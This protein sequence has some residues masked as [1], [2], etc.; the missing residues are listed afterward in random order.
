MSVPNLPPV[1]GY[2]KSGS[3]GGRDQ[4]SWDMVKDDK[5]RGN[6]LGNSVMAPTGRWCQGKDL[7]WFE[8]AKAERKE[9]TRDEKRLERLREEAA[10]NQAL[11]LPPPPELAKMERAREE[12]AEPSTKSQKRKRKNDLV[13][14]TLDHLNKSNRT[15]AADDFVD[16]FDHASSGRK[17]RR[18]SSFSSAS[19]TSS[20]S[21]SGAS[22]QRKRRD[23][24]KESKKKSKKSSK[25]KDRK[26]EKKRKKKSKK[27]KSKKGE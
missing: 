12:K 16:D 24:K 18:S 22:D 5:H 19:T 15:L 3:R 25:R 26:A 4:W 11:G 10:M 6:F 1:R 2:N 13:S 7:T 20:S 27:H 9:V 8:K 21:S 17:R 14:E 23:R